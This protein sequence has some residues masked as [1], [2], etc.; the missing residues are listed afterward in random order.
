MENDNSLHVIANNI[1]GIQNKNKRLSINEYFKNKTGNNGILFLQETHSTTSNEGK[2]KNE[3]SGPVFIYTVLLTLGVLI[4]FFEK[5]KIYVNI[6]VTDKHRRILILDGTIDGSEYIL[7][8]FYNANT[9]RVN[10]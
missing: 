1:K 2:W 7:V 8:N 4:T 5:N 9:K 3:F 6:Q 10:N